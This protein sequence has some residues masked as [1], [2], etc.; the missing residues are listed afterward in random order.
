MSYYK[1]ENNKIVKVEGAGS[2]YKAVGSSIGNLGIDNKLHKNKGNETPE[3]EP[4]IKPRKSPYKLNKDKVRAKIWEWYNVTRAKSS[5]KFITVSFPAGYP[6]DIAKKSL[7]TWLTR[8]RE[9]RKDFTYIWVAERQEN[10]TMHFHILTT[11]YFNIRIINRYMAKII[12]YQVKRE[13][14][15]WGESSLSKYNG[16]DLRKVKDKKGKNKRNYT[17]LEVIMMYVTKYI[18][19]NDVQMYGCVWNCSE[20]ISRL[21]TKLQIS[22]EQFLTI[23]EHL[24]QMNQYTQEVDFFPG[25][26]TITTFKQKDSGRIPL[27]HLLT[28]IN[29]KVFYGLPPDLFEIAD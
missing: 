3:F 20:N 12:D 17:A 11:E 28:N 25:L 16:V 8:L 26:L 6:D 14:A 27:Q 15:T 29:K 22:E 19:K 18:T 4:I 1:I 2:I 13:N 7:N 5:F 9:L 23:V 21:F 10:S 24:T